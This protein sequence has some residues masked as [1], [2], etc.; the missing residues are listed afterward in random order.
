[1]SFL[2]LQKRAK[3]LATKAVELDRMGHKEEAYV[4]YYRAAEL[5]LKLAEIAKVKR[6]KKEF[7]DMAN[8]YI[9]RCYEIK[10]LEEPSEKEIQTPEIPS[11]ISKTIKVTKEK[12]KEEIELEQAISDLVI[13]E[14]PNVMW[15]DVADL[16][17]A[18]QAIME[19]LILPLQHP[20]WFTGARKPWKGILLFGPPGCGK[21]H[22]ARAVATEI[23]ATFL[24]VD[25]ASI[26]IKWVGES[27]KRVKALFNFARLKQ[28]SIV[29]IDEIDAMVSARDSSGESG[30]EHRIKTQFL[31]EMDGILKSENEHVVVL[32][33]TNLPWALDLALRRRF[34]KRIYIP[35]PDETARKRIFEIHLKGIELDDSVDLDVLAQLTELYTAAD[36]A[37]V[38]RE[39][40]MMPIREV[41]EGNVIEESGKLRP[42]KQEDFEIALRKVKPSITEKELIK[43][44]AWAREFENR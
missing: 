7:V 22:I 32:A 12:T 29:F 23:K 41:Q 44:E 15:E 37:L 2:E 39:A 3:K 24:N 42:L 26:F 19:A 30:V 43:Y 13:T 11:E 8:K 1:L 16:E 5:L 33:A 14:K 20:E 21:T 28:P 35:P 6:L 31:T 38:C 9:K 40:A 25:A 17:D 34:E 18:K 27:E 10:G 4:Y 36:I